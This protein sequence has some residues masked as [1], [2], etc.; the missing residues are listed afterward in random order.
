MIFA[1]S[2]MALATVVP[3]QVILGNRLTIA[4]S[5]IIVTLLVSAIVDSLLV[6]I[7]SIYLA[8]QCT[9]VQALHGPYP[10]GMA[11]PDYKHLLLWRKLSNNA[12]GI[13]FVVANQTIALA[14]VLVFLSL[15]PQLWTMVFDDA[16]FSTFS[17]P[18]YV[19]MSI[20]NLIGLK[21]VAIGL[22]IGY[23][24]RMVS[25]VHGLKRTVRISSYIILL[26]L[27]A[28]VA[29]GQ[30]LRQ[31]YGSMFDPSYVFLALLTNGT[32][33]SIILHP[34][35]IAYPNAS[36]VN[37]VQESDFETFLSTTEGY[38]AFRRHLIEECSMEHLQFWHAARQFRI[39]YDSMG[40]AERWNNATIIYETYLSSSAP[41]QVNLS[42]DI[43]DHYARLFARSSRGNQV[44]PETLIGRDVF[45]RASTAVVQLM[46]LD[47]FA[48]FKS[49]H[50]DLWEAFLAR[51]REQLILDGISAPMKP[52]S[53]SLDFA[54]HG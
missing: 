54:I 21:G 1:V 47:S 36:P 31:Q 4:A 39:D 51:R 35:L 28:F 11:C 37:D 34:V 16:D 3:F 22:T 2:N 33:I 29:L 45:S 20:G 40:H 30:R 42:S 7:A 27:V 25:D 48:R 12:F 18:E 44:S 9:Q 26:C 6:V 17:S 13:A 38:E 32:F 8:F 46:V 19:V 49:K 53:T 23:K 15:H 43:S 52:T 5:S 24:I 10:T 41:L 14:A 50:R